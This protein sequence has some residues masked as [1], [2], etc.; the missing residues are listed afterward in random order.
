M[1]GL[2]KVVL[3]LQHGEIPAHLHFEEPNPYINWRAV[4]SAL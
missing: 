2:F 1:A 3:G 4:L